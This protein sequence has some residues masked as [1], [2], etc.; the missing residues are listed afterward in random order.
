MGPFETVWSFLPGSIVS[1]LCAYYHANTHVEF[2]IKPPD[3]AWLFRSG[4]P[5]LF[6]RGLLSTEPVMS[7]ESIRAVLRSASSKVALAGSPAELLPKDVRLLDINLLQTMDEGDQMYINLESKFFAQRSDEGD[8]VL[9]PMNGVQSADMVRGC[10]EAGLANEACPTLTRQP[11]DVASAAHLGRLAATFPSWDPDSLDQRVEELHRLVHSQKDTAIFFHCSC[12]CDRTGQLFASYAIRHLN[13]TVHTALKHNTALAGR[14]MWYEHQVSVQWYCEWLRST[15]HYL[16][17]DCRTCG[18]DVPCVAA[19]Y[20]LDPFARRLQ[21]QIYL[22]LLGLIALSILFRLL[23]SR[24]M[25]WTRK[26]DSL[27]NDLAAPFL[28]PEPMGPFGKPWPATPSTMSPSECSS[29]SFSLGTSSAA[30]SPKLAST[31]KQGAMFQWTRRVIE[32]DANAVHDSCCTI[33]EVL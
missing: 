3:G 1:W 29:P 31:P 22:A 2:V 30:S 26:G 5:W 13:W 32:T 18:G 33:E 16:H 14:A 11:R 24:V 17:D 19:E 25:R 20:Y 15:G 21:E 10:Q 12:G 9:W 23:G 6:P 28:T 27:K 8:F 7:A 4:G